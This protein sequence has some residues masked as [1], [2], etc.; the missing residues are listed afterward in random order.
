MAFRGV[1][2]RRRRTRAAAA[3]S[4]TCLALAA[5][6]EPGGPPA[7]VAPTTPL[8]AE[9]STRETAT[10]AAL[11]KRVTFTGE[12]GTTIGAALVESPTVPTSDVGVVVHYGSAANL[13]EWLSWGLSVSSQTG[14]R[15]LVFDRRGRGSTPAA[16]NIP[17]E[18]GD[19]VKA[20][21]Y[22]GSL[23]AKRI[24]LV[25]ASMGSAVTLSALPRLTL[26]TCV[27]LEV[28]P[29]LVAPDYRGVLDQRT[30]GR[31]TD[32]VW[33]TYET[34]G[35]IAITDNVHAIQQALA[36]QH[37]PEAHVMGIATGDHAR[38]LL[39]RNYRA[40]AFALDAVKSCTPVSTAGLSRPAAPTTG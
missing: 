8:T 40:E 39:W 31:L 18:V 24:A 37:L 30:P 34:N 20:T 29:I 15:V 2:V 17:A 7:P 35:S 38:R 33:L 25:G 21:D 5:C 12:D 9:C 28:S 27:L 14:A 6:G 36:D 19:T 32:N 1:M 10:A 23:G 4:L 13:C 3:I 16:P 11:A 22:L 26:P